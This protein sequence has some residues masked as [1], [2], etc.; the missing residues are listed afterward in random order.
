MKHQETKCATIRHSR[1]KNYLAKAA[2]NTDIIFDL[3][4][5]L[6]LEPTTG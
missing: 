5:L 6:S 1:R 3:Y 4:N 2:S